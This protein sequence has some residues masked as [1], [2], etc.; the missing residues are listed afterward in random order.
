MQASSSINSKQTSTA[1]TTASVVSTALNVRSNL[2]PR[3]GVLIV[4]LLAMVIVQM[5]RK[6]HV[7]S[8]ALLVAEVAVFSILP[9]IVY[10]FLRYRFRTGSEWLFTKTIVFGFQ[11]GAI[12]VGLLVILWHVALRA[13]G[14]GDAT[15]IVALVTV[16]SVS[17]YLAVFSKVPG[18]EKTS[19]ILSGALVFFVCCM[20][21][22]WKFFLIAG[23]F[24]FVGLWWLLGHY[25][26]RLDAKA[27]DGDSR[28][29]GLHGSTVSLTMLFI[30]LVVGLAA[31]IPFSQN[32]SPLAGFMPF[33]GGEN[34]KVDEFAISGIGDG[35]ML[36]AGLNATTTGAVDSDQFIEDHK[37]SLYDLTSERYEGPVKKKQNKRNKAMA[38]QGIAK[39]LHDAKRS[40]QA[41]R[42]FRTIRNRKQTTDVELRDRIT[43]A[44]FF[45]EGSVPAR[46]SI[47]NFYQFDGWDW[48]STPSES[49]ASKL[50]PVNP[51]E[52]TL[53][54]QSELPIF[55]FDRAIAG[56]LTGQRT[57]RIK[58]MRLDSSV[59]PQPAL[60]QRWHIPLVDR[61]DMFIWNEKKLIEMDVKSIPSYSIIDV[62]SL[63]PNYHELRDASGLQPVLPTS[64][65]AE[66]GLLQVPE[67]RSKV[68]IQRLAT[69]WT[70]GVEPGWAQ[71]ETVVDHLRNDFDLN[72]YWEVD[73]EAEDSVSL[74]LEQGGGPSYMFA[75]TCAMV[76]R[77]AGYRTRIAS[78]FLVQKHDYNSRARQSVVAADNLHMWPEVC[79]DGEFWIPVEP[80]P[81]YPIPFSTQTT[82]QWITTN[83]LMLYHWILANPISV[84]LFIGSVALTVL[85]RAE[86]VTSLMF[87][88]WF[89]VRMFWPQ[90]LL[91]TTRQLIDLRF[92]FAGDRRPASQTISAWY[93]RV[94]SSAL[95]TFFRFWNAKNYSDE[96]T[97]GSHQELALTCRSAISTLSLK[98]I[99]DFRRGN[100]TKSS[101]N[102]FTTTQK[103]DA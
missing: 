61:L 82:W 20:A 28:S 97:S 44:L 80:T 10:G 29:L 54:D 72:P 63:V 75:T 9:W 3:V 7:E 33:S 99:R 71:V 49:E 91:K 76:L 47:N 40:E 15:E 35:N 48:N 2:V 51:P 79:L 27:I 70:A 86:L 73:E 13:F 101:T 43:K 16:Q 68:A 96:P 36:T 18:F 81:G 57:H 6:G 64:E 4:S 100:Q 17:W 74:F 87:G 26:S 24:S 65:S 1:V 50:D 30:A 22:E 32:G 21:N 34:G 5:F 42:T 37:P 14:C 60:L 41:G 88:W 103:N 25:W 85:F 92:W 39:H 66:S 23:L 84:V 38:L 94:E 59:I 67:T 52:F 83:A 56:Y 31:M 55:E 12:L 89:L 69:E 95:D 8:V 78:G 102:D 62:E 93:T 58:I 53:Y 45:V 11:S 90:R 19:S 46:F 77:S 98:R